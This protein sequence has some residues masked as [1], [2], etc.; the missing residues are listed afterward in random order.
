MHLQPP[1]HLRYR[2]ASPRLTKLA[3]QWCSCQAAASMPSAP[4][5]TAS[6]PCPRCHFPV[7]AKKSR[8]PVTEQ[9]AARVL[10]A[11]PN[12]NAANQPRRTRRP[13]RT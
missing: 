5:A 2:G 4:E 7:S 10:L 6:A 8:E 11:R 3:Q 13:L 9:A 12:A 1:F